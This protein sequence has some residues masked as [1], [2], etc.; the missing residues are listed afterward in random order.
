MKRATVLGAL[1]VLVLL[2]AAKSPC[3]AEKWQGIDE[4]VVQKIAKEHGREAKGALINTGEGDLQLFAF[5]V[6]GAI[7]GFVAGYYWRVL[8]EGRKKGS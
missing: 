3:A 8:L 5:L 1:F 4:T 7:G 6:A 2:C